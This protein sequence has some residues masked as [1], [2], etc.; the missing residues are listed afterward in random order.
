MDEAWKKAEQDLEIEIDFKLTLLLKSGRKTFVLIR[1]FGAPRGTIVTSIDD[2][3]DFGEL[4]KLGFHCSAIGN[5]YLNYDRSLFVDTLNDW[6]FFG[7][8]HRKPS[9]YTGENWTQL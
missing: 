6:G 5:S 7:E 8:A 2:T 1:N 4:Q 9:W 3:Q